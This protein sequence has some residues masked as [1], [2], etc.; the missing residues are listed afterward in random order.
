MKISDRLKKK[1]LF[2]AVLGIG[3]LFLAFLTV[4]SRAVFTARVARTH[5]TVDGVDY[6]YF[7]DVRG[8]SD[9]TT[10]VT[11]GNLTYS[12]LVLKR[13]FVTEPSLYL[14]ARKYVHRRLGV[15]DIHLSMENEDGEV[16]SQVV[17]KDCQPLTW[18]VEAANPA[19]GGFHETVE[20]A[21]QEIE[22]Y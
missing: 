8:L 22:M 12:K 3:L 10:R 18:S 5:V 21:V 9:L 13:D 1:S 6:G 19:L 7:E 16:L 17:L 2:P 11:E 4:D 15:K 14:W 20:L